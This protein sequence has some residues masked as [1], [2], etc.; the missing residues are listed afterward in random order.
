MNN[1]VLMIVISLLTKIIV[2][3]VFAV[4]EQP[5]FPVHADNSLTSGA[6]W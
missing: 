6:E 2:I 4:I 3:M 1:R 5:H